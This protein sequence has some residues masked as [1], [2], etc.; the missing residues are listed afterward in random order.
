MCRRCRCNVVCWCTVHRFAVFFS[1]AAL[2]LLFVIFR[3]CCTYFVFGR[4]AA[5]FRQR[6]CCHSL[7]SRRLNV[8]EETTEKKKIQTA[9]QSEDVCFGCLHCFRRYSVLAPTNSDVVHMMAG[10]ITPLHTVSSL[11]HRQQHSVVVSLNHKYLIGTSACSAA[12]NGGWLRRAGTFPIF[13]GINFS[14][15]VY[16][17]SSARTQTTYNDFLLCRIFPVHRTTAPLCRCRSK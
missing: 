7:L 10:V 3:L 8:C 5:L 2:L 6:K 1:S 17:C 13:A 9:K 15:N 4:V 11:K 12:H 14:N 16:F